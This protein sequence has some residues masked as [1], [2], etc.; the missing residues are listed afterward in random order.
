M[1]APSYNTDLTVINVVD[2]AG[3]T[4]NWSALGGGSSGLASETDY[5]IQGDGCIS[6]AGFTATTKGMI[7]NAGTTTITSGDA[8]FMW[9]KQNNRNL[10]DTQSNGGQQLLIGTGTGAYDQFYID[11][12]DSP[13]SDLAGWRI[14][15]VDP[16]ATPS[17]TTGTPGA[18]PSY[19]GGQWKILGSGSL[20]GNPNGIDAFRHGREIQCTDGDV[21]NGYATFTG[22]GST[23]ATTSNRW[24]ILT[25]TAGS[26]QFHGCFVMGTASTSVDF[27]DSNANIVV[28]EDEFVASTFNEFEIRN[29]SSNVQWGSVQ[30]S[31]LGTTS[32]STLTLNVGTFTGDSNRFDGCATTTFNSNGSSS[33]TNTTWVNSGQIILNEA[34]ISGSNILTPTVAA[35][36]GAVY[37]NRTTTAAV[38][39]SELDGTSFTMGTNSHHAIR[40]GTGVTHDVTL[41]NIDFTGFGT[42]DDA[43]DSTFRFDATSGS[44]T[45][46]LVNCT[47]NGSAAS[48]ANIS[49]DDAAGVTVTLSIDPVTTLVNVKDEN[50]NN[51]SGASVY[52]RAKDGTGDL[53]YQQSISSITRSTTTATVTFAA[54]HGLKVNQYLKL[55]G[56]TDKTEDN[57]GA[58]QVL[59][60]PSATTLTYATTDS[61]STSYT[62]TIVGTGVVLYGTTNASGN[63]SSSNTWSSNQP[64]FGR[65]RKATTSPLYKQFQLDDTINSTSGLT[66]NVR[67]IRDD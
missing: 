66:L 58:H 26:Y 63:I 64:V 49:I 34:D 55:S 11:G 8:V 33:C 30:I 53:P 36:E 16:T 9:M 62:G 4:T 20:K 27:R 37:D 15:A 52:L 13:G 17:N 42:T 21:T 35:D 7:Y 46:S 1:A 12:S 65:V 6:K 3:G 44:I 32:P 40:F 47:V 45:L 50:G 67:L 59:T 10:M 38:I 60:V 19:F 39:A 61:G 29:T 41:R 43:N 57:N 48:D 28:L 5:Y 18:T 22:A 31:H 24:G 51:L 25:P 2:T 56:I 54:A 23:D 14:F